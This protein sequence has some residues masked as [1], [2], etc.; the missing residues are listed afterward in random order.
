MEP[1]EADAEKRKLMCGEGWE[2][3]VAIVD[4]TLGVAEARAAV[5]VAAEVVADEGGVVELRRSGCRCG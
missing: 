2:L 5:L 4:I 1:G 3:G